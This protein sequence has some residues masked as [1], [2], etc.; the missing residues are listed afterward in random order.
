MTAT[1]RWVEVPFLLALA[2]CPFVRAD[3]PQSLGGDNE[4]RVFGLAGDTIPDNSACQVGDENTPFGA[5][6]VDPSDGIP[7]KR[8]LCEEQ[9]VVVEILGGSPLGSR[10]PSWLVIVMILRDCWSPVH[11]IIP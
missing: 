4:C 8:S 6:Q 1:R 11:S 5:P 3:E 9:A 7:N 10:D 2:F